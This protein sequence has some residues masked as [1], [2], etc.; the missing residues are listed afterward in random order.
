MDLDKA[1]DALMKLGWSEYESKTYAALVKVGLATASHVAKNSSVPS[2]KVYQILDKLSGN[3]FVEK[4]QGKGS[5]TLYVAK[6]PNDVLAMVRKEY[7]ALLIEAEVALGEIQ[8]RLKW[9][10]FPIAYTIT[11]RNELTS[12]LKE[13]IINADN[14]ICLTLDT[15]SELNSG[16]LAKLLI[17]KYQEGVK[18]RIVTNVA[19]INDP[20]EIEA[21]HRIDP[22]EV[23][24]L[25]GEINYI[26]MIVDETYGIVACYSLHSNEDTQ[27]EFTGLFVED[28]SFA[29]ML[30]LSFMSQW[31][32]STPALRN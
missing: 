11:S 1:V 3:G 15:L 12:H 2:N 6:P 29:T 17:S 13:L 28:R 21:Y 4:I 23:R 20:Y 30:R 5:P 10:E 26:A 19:G 27:K 22:L 16:R 32:K 24:I 9:P 14:E 25:D 7:E 31:E 18:I 8:E